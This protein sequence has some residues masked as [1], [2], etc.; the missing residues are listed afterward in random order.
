M[1]VRNIAL[2]Q[3]VIGGYQ[4]CWA[5]ESPKPQTLKYLLLLR[6]RPGREYGGPKWELQIDDSVTFAYLTFE[7][8]QS[9]MRKGH[10]RMTQ[11]V[12][13]VQLKQETL[14]AFLAYT[15]DAETEM[16]ATLDGSTP[17]LWSDENADRARHVRKGDVLSQLWSGQSPVRVPNGLI[18]D[19]IGA[20]SIRGTT[21]EKTLALVQDY[22]NHKNIYKPDVMDS[23][24]ISHHG[25]D[26]IIYLRLL[27]KKIITVVL[28][29]EHDVHYQRVD[30]HQWF[31]RSHTTRIAEVDDAGTAKEK[32]YP[33]DTGYG[34]LWRL[35]S[36]WKFMGREDA[37]IVECRA[38]SLTRDVPLGLGWIIEP[39]INSLP[40]ESLLNTLK[41]TR[42]ALMVSP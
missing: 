21:I 39:I 22:D 10:A 11:S 2:Q 1:E 37:V 32:V 5:G 27:K 35:Y 9:T 20:I 24:L 7:Y 42:Q 17:F 29:T 26:F 4:E 16:N 12:S 40:R 15:A 41:A 19:W 25:N 31:L 3:G 23:R 8:P 14:D 6:V 38:V 30:D 33:P 28:D 13:V 34:F 36:Y 18:H